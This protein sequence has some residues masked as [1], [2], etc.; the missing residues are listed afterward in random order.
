MR[1]NIVSDF[2][3]VVAVND[4]MIISSVTILE[5]PSK[6]AKAYLIVRCRTIFVF[7][8]FPDFQSTI[9]F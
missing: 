4:F 9:A 7:L 1:T 6:V 3:L 2:F 8:T 5:T